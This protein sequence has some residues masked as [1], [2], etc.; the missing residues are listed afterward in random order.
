MI[1][2]RSMEKIEQQEAEN[3]SFLRKVWQE[4]I[5]NGDAGE[6]DFTALKKEA[7]ASRRGEQLTRRSG[8]VIKIS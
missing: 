8:V 4:G 3:L 2:T 5:D 7:R 1:P 6:V